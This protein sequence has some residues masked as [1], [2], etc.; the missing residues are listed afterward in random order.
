[1]KTMSMS[2]QRP[3]PQ[4]SPVL[5]LPALLLPPV[6]SLDEVPE[7][8]SPVVA[9]AAPVL[10][11]V[12]VSLVAL[13]LEVTGA[14]AELVVGGAAP[15]DPLVCA[16]GRPPQ[17]PSMHCSS[18]PQS[19]SEAHGWPARNLPLKQAVSAS[20]HTAWSERCM[21]G[22]IGDATS[23]HNGGRRVAGRSG[24]RCCT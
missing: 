4:V 20:A 22:S 17:A 16:A 15:L 14:V 12:G 7:L 21:A 9:E 5:L 8:A 6:P 11:L 18:V 3:T 10:V 23:R 1:M 2:R 13:S 19:G 24:A